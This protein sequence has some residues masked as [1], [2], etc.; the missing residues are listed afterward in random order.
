MGT[1]ITISIHA[2]ALDK[3]ERDA[4]AHG[5]NKSAYIRAL[6]A[7]GLHEPEPVMAT[8][9]AWLKLEPKQ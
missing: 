5:M 1:V 8:D 2:E 4:R 9:D 6:I 3:L 7:Q